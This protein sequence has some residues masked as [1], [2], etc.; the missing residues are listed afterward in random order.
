MHELLRETLAIGEGELE[1][2]PQGLAL[3][4]LDLVL[5]YDGLD[6]DDGIRS[7]RFQEGDVADAV[8]QNRFVVLEIEEGELALVFLRKFACDRGVHIAEVYNRPKGEGI[9]GIALGAFL[10]TGAILQKAFVDAVRHGGVE[11]ELGAILAAQFA[12]AGNHVVD[13]ELP[14]HF[15]IDLSGIGVEGC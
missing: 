9:G 5:P 4:K 8:V 10:A 11:A 14:T 1:F 2:G 13:F 15:A 12:A 6:V 7:W 3:G